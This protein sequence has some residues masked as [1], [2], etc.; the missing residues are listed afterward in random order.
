[1]AAIQ[2]LT[3]YRKAF[4]RE[5]G[6]Q[7]TA[8]ETARALHLE[9]AGPAMRAVAYRTEANKKISGALRRQ[10]DDTGL[11]LACRQRCIQSLRELN[12]AGDIPSRR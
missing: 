2:R 6:R 4:F 10:M 8:V 5:R 12:E 11:L 3:E 9:L 7:P 1:M